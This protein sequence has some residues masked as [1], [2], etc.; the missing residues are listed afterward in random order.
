M[1]KVVSYAFCVFRANGTSLQRHAIVF[2]TGDP[3]HAELVLLRQCLRA[4][5]RSPAAL[6]LLVNNAPKHISCGCG[7]PRRASR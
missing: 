6:R 4:R 7:S 1:E 2:G 5:A 3:N